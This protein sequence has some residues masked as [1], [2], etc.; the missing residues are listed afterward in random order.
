MD[1][2]LNQGVCRN[3]STCNLNRTATGPYFNA[4]QTA[5]AQR[6]ARKPPSL[7][8]LSIDTSLSALDTGLQVP[9]DASEALS[10]GEIVE[11]PSSFPFLGPTALVSQRA[12]FARSVSSSGPREGEQ[13]QHK[14]PIRGNTICLWHL[15]H[16]GVAETPPCKN[17]NQCDFAHVSIA[18]AEQTIGF[19]IDFQH[20][21][22]PM[23]QEG[24]CNRPDTCRFN[25][26]RSKFAKR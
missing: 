21:C 5:E 20:L 6:E 7:P 12:E 4:M 18:Q 19:R 23:L 15:Q 26:R 14:G 16:L 11:T 25:Y 17:G 9:E 13:T 8:S 1:Q 22:M 24:H 3:P 10:P 2:L